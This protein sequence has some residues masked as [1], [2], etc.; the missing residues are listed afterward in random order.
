[1]ELVRLTVLFLIAMVV[2]STGREEAFGTILYGLL[3][4]TMGAVGALIV[5]RH[6]A[7]PIGWIFIAHGLFGAFAKAAEGWGQF[8]AEY[9]LPGG[10]AGEWLI[11]WSWIVVLSAG[12][13]VFLL[14]S[15]GH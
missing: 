10:P 9:D 4:L 13:L 3:S 7:N 6:P 1:M 2:L 14:F 11:L 5:S 12:T 15:G 8:V